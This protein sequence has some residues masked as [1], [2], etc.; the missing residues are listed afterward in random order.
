MAINGIAISDFKFESLQS[1][2][3]AKRLEQHFINKS[4]IFNTKIEN[5]FQTMLADPVTLVPQELNESKEIKKTSLP[6]ET[7]FSEKSTIDDFVKS[8]WPYAQKAG[9]YLGLDPRILLAQ[10]AL[11]TG[12]GKFITKDSQGL[13]SNNL[14]NIKASQKEQEAV[15]S[16]TTEYLDNKALKVIASFKKYS[17]IASSFNDY[18]SLIQ[19]SLR[20]EKA[21][22]NTSDPKRY[23]DE[24]HKAGYATDPLYANKILAIYKGNELQQALLRN[25][26]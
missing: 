6:S 3:K 20:Y 7:S 8:A 13:S 9:E 16:K 15:Q 26:F 18:V 2:L 25:G 23:V 10:A 24:L 21:L 5:S 4:N 19:G 14:F 22:A 1:D 17:S 12:W 11:E